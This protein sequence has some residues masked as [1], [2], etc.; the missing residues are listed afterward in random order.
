LPAGPIFTPG[1]QYEIASPGAA[2]SGRKK[3]AGRE[4]A[5]VDATSAA[6]PSIAKTLTPVVQRSERLRSHAV[7]PAH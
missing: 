3:N 6:M 2:V 7:R 1:D 4:A 5:A